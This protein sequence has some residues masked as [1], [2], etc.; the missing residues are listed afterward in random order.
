MA[1]RIDIE[2]RTI[3][4]SVRDLAAEDAGPAGAGLPQP[5]RAA[6][7]R[8]EHARIQAE[9]ASESDEFSSEVHVRYETESL[10]FRVIVRGRIDGV[11]REREDGAVRLEEVKTIVSDPASFGS[12]PLGDALETSWIHQARLYGALLLACGEAA[13]IRVALI[14]VNV[15]DGE[16]REVDVPFD[17]DEALAFLRERIDAL[18]SEGARRLEAAARREAMAAAIRFP[19]PEM[20]P[21]Q[22]AM[23]EA[24]VKAIARSRHLLLSAPTGVGKTAAILFAAV[25][26]AYRRG[27]RVIY[28]TA[29]TTQRA[30]VRETLERIRGAGAPIT[31]VILR[32]KDEICP[33]ELRVCQPRACPL[34]AGYV[35]RREESNVIR[36]LLAEGIIGPERVQEVAKGLRLCPFELALDL[37]LE[38]DCIVCDY[39]HVFDP[40]AYLR[41]FFAGGRWDD[42]VLLV[43]EAHNLP[44]RGREMYSPGLDR[45]RIRAL[46]KEIAGREGALADGR[47][48]AERLDREIRKLA[49]AARARAEPHA[50][51]DIDRDVFESLREAIEDSATRYAIERRASGSY[52]PDDPFD[53][54]YWEFAAFA[55]VLGRWGREFLAY[56]ERTPKPG[57]AR[58][59]CRDPSRLLGDRLKGFRSAIAFSATLE[60]PEFYRTML[61]LE[62][63]RTDAIALPSPF[64]RENRIIRIV[65]DFSTRLRDRPRNYPQIAALVH[66]AT[67]LRRGN[68]LAFLPSFVFLDEIERRLPRGPYELLVQKPGMSRA[69]REALLAHLAE[70]GGYHLVLAVQGGV[71]AEG[72]DYPGERLIGAIVVGPGLPQ[73]DFVQEQLRVYLQEEYGAGFAFAYAIPGMTRTIQSVGRVIRSETD[74]GA[75]LLVCDRFLRIPYRDLLPHEW[76]DKEPEE[77]LAR[78]PLADIAAFWARAARECR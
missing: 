52:S 20:R 72:V 35:R 68:Y 77:L 40:R 23:I 51:V 57:A 22:D 25:R 16:A 42:V 30:L 58:I 13:R 53:E 55:A 49:K 45:A 47:R 56:V 46:V 18:A 73:R 70:P 4:A 8:R 17:P 41:R 1:I 27:L 33:H 64:P 62:P 78:R 37:A 6:I 19:F 44:A 31:A 69:D 34:L 29:K 59:L 76:F 66:A 26:E 15:V 9:R 48:A 75:V 61:G 32:A 3:L 12:A 39:N 65:P 67:L 60:P 14:I 28:A 50:T 21:H 38:V 71:F 2:T 74:R 10:G 63:W 7:G 24:V 5:G 43:D 54:F 36:E 11:D